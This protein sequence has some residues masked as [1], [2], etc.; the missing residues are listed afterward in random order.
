MVLL[1]IALFICAAASCIIAM[2]SVHL[3]KRLDAKRSSPYVIM[4]ATQNIP[5]YGVRLVNLGLTAARNVKVV[6]NPKIEMLFG[7]ERKPIRFLEE[8]I[9]VLVPK[10]MC[11]TDFCTWGDLEKSNPSLV[12]RCTVSYES[13]WGEK[14]SNECVLDYSLYD[15]LAYPEKKT[16]NDLVKQL[17]NLSREFNLFA[18]GFHTPHVLT[19]DYDKCNEKVERQREERRAAL[20]ARKSSTATQCGGGRRTMWPR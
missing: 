20:A 9:A 13:E 7:S 12:Y 18:T 10:G 8:S 16:M 1:T 15:G 11:A 5:F 2:K 19:E 4:E 17:E 14:M 3:M 6:M